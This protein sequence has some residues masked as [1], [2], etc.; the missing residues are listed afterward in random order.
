M[1]P[2]NQTASRNATET[3]PL[4]VAISDRVK[5]LRLTVGALSAVL[6][7]I[8]AAV[9]MDAAVQLTSVHLQT[10]AQPGFVEKYPWSQPIFFGI[11]GLVGVLLLLVYFVPSCLLMRLS[12]RHGQVCAGG[13]FKD[14]SDTLAAEKRV[15]GYFQFISVS[16]VLLMFIAGVAALLVRLSLKHG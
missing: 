11:C 6:F 3:Q 4:P 9:L 5:T 7:L 15:W 10:I 1:E 8:G 13:R 16:A 14:L 2:P 12:R